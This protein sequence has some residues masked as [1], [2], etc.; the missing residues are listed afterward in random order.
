VGSEQHRQP[1]WIAAGPAGEHVTDGINPDGQ[2]EGF[3]LG[4]EAVAAGF[5]D[6]GQSE[7]PDAAL[8]GGANFGEAHEGIPQALAI[9]ALV[10]L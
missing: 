3:A 8:R 2:P 5:V 6:A 10:G 9:D 1:R 7:T 4:A